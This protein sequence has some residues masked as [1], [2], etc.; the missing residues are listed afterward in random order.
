ME[1]FSYRKK[2]ERA[3]N[4]LFS[5]PWLKLGGLACQLSERLQKAFPFQMDGSEQE[6]L[7]LPLFKG[8]TGPLWWLYIPDVP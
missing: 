1:I 3:V 2:R 8:T 7:Y 6:K 5:F 4:E